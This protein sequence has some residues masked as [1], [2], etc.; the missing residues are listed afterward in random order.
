MK[1]F[2]LCLFCICASISMQGAEK[3][4][5]LY[6]L[7]CEQEENPLGIEA[8][9]PRFS[10]KIHA[11]QRG[12]KQSA[13]QLLVA[14]SPECLSS[15]KGLAWNSG[16]IKSGQSVLVSYEGDSLKPVTRYYW[17]VRIGDTSGKVSEW[18]LP[19]CGLT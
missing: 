4:F 12:F 9:Q 11:L 18:S 7:Q 2:F 1:T 19:Q 6:N 16:K 8:R 15:G 17:K 14:D 5:S 13:Y 10:W 3:S